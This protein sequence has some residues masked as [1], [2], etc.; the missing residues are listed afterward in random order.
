MNRHQFQIAARQFRA[1]KI[2]LADFT[3]RVLSPAGDPAT[4]DSSADDP[5]P[6]IPRRRIDSHKGSYGHV[7]VIAGSRGMAGAAAL[8]GIAAL[9]SGAGLVTV[10]TARSVQM[11]VSGFHPAMM[12]IGL[13]EDTHGRIALESWDKLAMKVPRADCLAIGPG[14]GT[15]PELRELVRDIFAHA[16]LPA[17]LDADAL[18]NLGPDVSRPATGHG[19]I[20]TPHPGELNRLL[21]QSLKARDELEASATG[22]AGRWGCVTILKGHGSLVT[23]GRI[24][25]R[26][27]TG[28]PGMA[29]AGAGDVLTGIVA[30]LI[31]QGLGAWQAA[32]LGCH[33]HGLAGDCAVA[34]L[35]LHGLVATDIIDF[36]PTALN[37]LLS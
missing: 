10:A 36:V 5:L 27:S 16:G 1:G 3:D 12:T 29:T 26:N 18:N 28:N 21:G 8:A 25:R 17:V 34:Q 6:Q 11:V 23:D 31:G 24:S 33:L 4:G 15:S 2:S 30:S 7:L 32:V 9:R 20:L 37:S 14:M 22:L 13:D 35:G 19:R